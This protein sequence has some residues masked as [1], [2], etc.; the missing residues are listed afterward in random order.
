MRCLPKIIR[1]FAAKRMSKRRVG[2]LRKYLAVFF[3]MLSLFFAGIALKNKLSETAQ[4]EML[5]HSESTCCRWGAEVEAAARSSGKLVFAVRD[6]PDAFTP[7]EKLKR[8]LAEHYISVSISPR[9]YPADTAVIDHFFASA[10]GHKTAFKAGIFSPNLVPIYM[11]SKTETANGRLVPNLEN[12]ILGAAAQFERNPSALKSKAKSAAKMADAPSDFA[13]STDIFS[14]GGKLGFFYSESARLF[15][16]F[17]NP[18]TLGAPP[19][20]LSENARLAF[21]IAGTDIRQLAARV[22]SLSAFE[23]LCA[24]ISSPHETPTSRL[25]F[26]RAI[27]DSEYVEKNPKATRFFLHFAKLV[28]DTPANAQPFAPKQKPQ[29]RD[30]ALSVPILL[31]AYKFSG[32]VRY[33]ERAKSACKI[34]ESAIFSRGV[35]PAVA[36]EKSEASALEYVLCARAFFEMSKTNG[37]GEKNTERTLDRLDGFFMTPLGI[38]SINAKDSAFAK[39][40]RT[41]FTRDSE[42]PSYVGEAAQLFAEDRRLKD[43]PAARILQK[44]ASAATAASPFESGQWSSLKLSLVPSFESQKVHTPKESVALADA[45]H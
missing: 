21:G 41:V 4:P 40:S 42:L 36:G 37:T 33:L 28:A 14:V 20:E 15:T 44:L 5:R 25:L 2:K 31:R 17:A 38:W 19:A 10:V 6:C 24:R 26:M 11:T 12:A 7:P 43:R 13:A 16:Y 30:I 1:H 35:M 22:A 45:Q 8:T 34:L 9:K 29:M 32:N 39:I 23:M 3:G 27:S 18:R